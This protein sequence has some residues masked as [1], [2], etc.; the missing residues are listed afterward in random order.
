MKKPQTP[1]E[2]I[3]DAKQKHSPSH[4]VFNSQLLYLSGETLIDISQASSC[5]FLSAQRFALR[6]SSHT[7]PT[8]YFQTIT[9]VDRTERGSERPFVMR[10]EQHELAAIHSSRL[11]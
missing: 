1:A 2:P 3:T 9:A 8:L 7:R 4:H 5:S 6:K 10:R 11:L